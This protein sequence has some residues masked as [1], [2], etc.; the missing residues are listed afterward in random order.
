MKKRKRKEKNNITRVAHLAAPVDFRL[1]S[2]E[3]TLRSCNQTRFKAPQI[4]LE[5]FDRW[6]IETFEEHDWFHLEKSR[7]NW[8]SSLAH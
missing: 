6:L 8:L 2:T 4:T 1:G 7:Y 5:C 3:E